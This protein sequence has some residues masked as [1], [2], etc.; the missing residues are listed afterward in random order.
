MSSVLIMG[1]SGSLGS[2]SE[3]LSASLITLDVNRVHTCQPY[4]PVGLDLKLLK[5]ALKQL[6]NIRLEWSPGWLPGVLVLRHLW[7]QSRPL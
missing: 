3:N 7:G 2:S 1:L 5:R 4:S 6:T